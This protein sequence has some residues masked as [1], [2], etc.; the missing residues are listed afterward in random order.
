MKNFFGWD[1][2]PTDQ[3][4]HWSL[5]TKPK[6]LVPFVTK[7]REAYDLIVDNGLEN[8]MKTLLEAA[9][10]AGGADEHEAN[11]GSEM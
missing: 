6:E 10:E 2:H 3:Y 8:N 11:A 7:L 5:A 9:Y 4:V 1:C